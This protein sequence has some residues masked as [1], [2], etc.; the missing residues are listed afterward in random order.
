MAATCSFCQESVIW[1]K[2]L[3]DGRIM[4][5]ACEPIEFIRTYCTLGGD[6]SG[7]PFEPNTWFRDMLRNVFGI[8]TEEGL[9]QIED[10]YLEVPK[11]NAK[12][13][14]MAAL[15]IWGL[16]TAD[17]QGTEIYSAA[18]KKDQ[19]ANTYKAAEQMVLGNLMLRRRLVCLPGKKRIQRR[20][21]PTSFYMAL[22]GDGNTNDGMIPW[23]VIRDEL[24]VWKGEKLEKLYGII[25]KSAATKRLNPLIID[26]TTA[27]EQDSSELCWAR[28]EYT[29]LVNSGLIKDPRF[30]GRIYAANHER[31]ETDP[32][33]WKTKEARLEANPAHEDHGGHV[34]DSALASMVTKAETSRLLEVEYKRYHL[35]Y[36]GTN[37]AAAIDY[38]AWV[39]CTGGV[40]VRDWPEFDLEFL[41]SKWKLAGNP[42]YLGL[43]LGT[44]N[45]LTAL[46]A[47]FPPYEDRQKWAIIPFYWMPASRVEHRQS[48]DNVPYDEWIGRKFIFAHDSPKT[49]PMILLPHIKLLMQYFDV[50]ALCYDDWNAS[51]LINRIETGDEHGLD[52]IDL[53]CKEVEQ[54]TKQLNEPT[55]WI[56][57]V[58]AQND[59]IMHAYHPV[60]CWN[61]R[62]LA[63]KADSNN[64]VKPLKVG[65][66]SRKKIDGMAALITL[67][68]VGLVDYKQVSD[69]VNV[70]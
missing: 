52:I 69:Y 7:R 30:F 57:E 36:W 16:S 68:R 25:E 46:V 49:H 61:A 41:M 48:R 37:H 10:C 13:Q 20:D 27:G 9:R 32:N 28:H 54:N 19:A 21:D 42:C 59:L 43:D 12:T 35:N 58:A 6:Y 2:P 64:N 1:A 33:Y 34:R 8:R 39:K 31:M 11:G 23:M 3:D 26:I 67:L 65:E 22:S 4:C 53:P 62:N 55:K 63:L 40:D 50:R 60:L 51:S 70:R 5:P 14:A 24:H 66:Q 56:V 18:T 15:V 47:G 29:E 38:P 17:K 45:D 44:T